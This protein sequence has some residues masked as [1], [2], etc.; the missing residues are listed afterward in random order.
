MNLHEYQAKKLLARHGV[1]VPLGGVV[2]NPEEINSVINDLNGPTWVV[3]AQIHAGGRGKAGG[4]KVVNSASDAIKAANEIFG[5]TLVTPQTGPG[6]KEVHR[7]YIEEGIQIDR[8][9]YLSLLVDRSLKKVTLMASTEGGMNI[10][11]VAEKAPDK[12]LKQV[13]DPAAGMLPFHARKIA[14]GLGLQGKQVQSA[15]KLILSAYDAFMNCDASLVEINPLVVSGDSLVAVDA[16]ITIDDDALFRQ[17]EIASMRDES[18]EDPAEL[19]AQQNNLNYI[20]LDG[21]IGCLVNGAG[22]AMATMDIIK[23]HGGNPA[24]FLDVGGGA[25]KER[26]VEAFKIILRD[27][28]VKGILVNIFAGIN[29]CDVV[30]SGV[31][32]A[33]KE[34]G[35]QVPLVVRLEGTKIEEGKKL[36]SDSGLSIIAADGLTDAAEKIVAA[37]GNS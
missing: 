21:D 5:M 24:N 33:V 25:P 29:R 36:L 6:G 20:K 37:T 1:P 23:F 32:E 2:L 9:L 17:K 4:V 18:E 8:E 14:F 11:E 3:K 7:V 10:E 22:L 15:V 34:V 16:K 12:I 30:A 31:I 13:I 26:V 27:Q 35:I 19:I 28:N